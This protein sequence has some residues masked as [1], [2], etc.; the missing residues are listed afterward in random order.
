MA[1]RSL[2][3]EEELRKLS[4]RA[5]VAYAARCARRV[6]PLSGWSSSEDSLAVKVAIS[7]GELIAS[8]PQPEGF[9]NRGNHVLDMFA[10]IP[11]AGGGA[12]GFYYESVVAAACAVAT[13]ADSAIV[14]GRATAKGWTGATFDR[15]CR[16]AICAAGT[17]AARDNADADAA[18]RI[19]AAHTARAASY[20]SILWAAC[21]D[22]AQLIPLSTEPCPALGDPINLDALGLLWLAGEPDWYRKALKE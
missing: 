1:D 13:A 4:L 14:A 17:A 15:A 18:V 20:Q 9:C 19:A 3:T 10:R 11:G 2:P 6:Q 12:S 21:H 5:V 22:F 16:D 7:F 8:H